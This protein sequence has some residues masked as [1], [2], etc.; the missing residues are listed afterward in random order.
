MLPMPP[1]TEQRPEP[2]NGLGTAGFVLGLIGLIFS[3]IPLIGV[4]AWPLVILGIVLGGVGF[5]RV[6][7]GKATNKGLTIAGVVLSIIGLVIC[8]VWTAA[9]GKVAN[10]ASKV[11]SASVAPA[12][13]GAAASTTQ[14]AQTAGK[15]HTMVLEVTTHTKSN[16]EWSAG[17]NPGHQ[18]VIAGGQTWTQTLSMDSLDPTMLSVSPVD[19]QAG[20]ANNTCKITV[21]GKKVAENSNPFGAICTYTPGN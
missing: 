3:F 11:P 6:R 20:G 14:A 9:F 15:A 19:I 17:L 18:D 10:D 1:A 12:S 2:K 5:A 4:V 16:V 21:D 7:S 8:I 13:A